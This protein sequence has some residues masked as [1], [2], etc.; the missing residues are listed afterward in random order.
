MLLEGIQLSESPVIPHHE[1]LHQS[2]VPRHQSL[3]LSKSDSQGNRNVI[4][5]PRWKKRLFLWNWSLVSIYSQKMTRQSC[6]ACIVPHKC[7]LMLTLANTCGSWHL[8]VEHWCMMDE[9][10]DIEYYSA[11]QRVPKKDVKGWQSQPTKKMPQQLQ[12]LSALNDQEKWSL[13][14]KQGTEEENTRIV[15]CLNAWF[16]KNMIRW[17]KCKEWFHLRICINVFNNY[18][19]CKVT[20]C[21][22]WLCLKWLMLASCYGNKH[23]T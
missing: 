23:H 10:W 2:L 3:P 13:C 21:I 15:E 4:Y 17:S 8:C 1:W 14:K 9:F 20:P 12:V 6:F 22:V 19:L 16:S 5:E 11:L 7:M 18:I